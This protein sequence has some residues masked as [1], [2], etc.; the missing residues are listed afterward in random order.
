M[1]PYPAQLGVIDTV[2]PNTQSVYYDNAVITF[3]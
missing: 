2:P 3:Q 1:P